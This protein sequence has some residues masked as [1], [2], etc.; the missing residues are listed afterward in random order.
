LA[1]VLCTTVRSPGGE[2]YH[3]IGIG[4]NGNNQLFPED[5]RDNATCLASELSR[6]IVL[7]ELTGCLLAELQWM[8]GLLHYDEAQALEE[9]KSC[10]EG[11][12]SLLLAVWRELCDTPGR[13]VEYGFDVQ[14][15]PLYQGIVREIDPWGGL[16]MELADGSSVTE[17]SG[18]IV[19]L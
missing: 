9:D 12:N 13:R 16:V 14:Q 5:I 6:K 1:G 8:I 18:E 4:I 3:L 19:Y 7:A 17:Y 11:R 15:Q 10:E 2:Q